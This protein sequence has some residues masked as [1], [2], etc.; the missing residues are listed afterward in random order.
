MGGGGGGVCT[1]DSLHA[2]VIAWTSCIQTR[3]D[4]SWTGATFRVFGGPGCLL[5]T[6]IGRWWGSCNFLWPDLGGGEGLNSS[7]NRAHFF[8]PSRS[9]FAHF[10]G[11]P[12]QIIFYVPGDCSPSPPSLRRRWA[13][14]QMFLAC[15]AK[16]GAGLR[17]TSMRLRVHVISSSTGERETKKTVLSLLS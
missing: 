11:N 17:S 12:C 13:T 7:P 1:R 14:L 4:K 16:K 15:P 6:R 3:L 10:S 2:M 9:V 8:T 5:L